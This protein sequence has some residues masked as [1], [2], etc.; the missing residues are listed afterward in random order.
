MMMM[1]DYDDDDH[2][3]DHDDD[4]YMNNDEWI[5]HFLYFD[6]IINETYS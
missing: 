4:E 3:H 5:V 6:S 2:D 1:D